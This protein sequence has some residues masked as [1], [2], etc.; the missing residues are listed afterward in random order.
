MIKQLG[1]FCCAAVLF[2][3]VSSSFAQSPIG[4]VSTIKPKKNFEL[5]IIHNGQKLESVA[6]DTP[7]YV[8]DKVQTGPSTQVII[9]FE[10]GNTVLLRQGSAMIVETYEHQKKGKIRTEGII[11]GL[12][13]NNYQ[14][15]ADSYF[16]FTSSS[17]IA[18]VRGSIIGVHVDRNTQQLTAYL[19]EGTKPAY[20]RTAQ[21]PIVTDFNPNN[22]ATAS[23]QT[24]AAVVP[25]NPDL[26]KTLQ[27]PETIV[28]GIK[29]GDTKAF[30]QPN[31]LDKQDVTKLQEST[32][33]AASTETTSAPE[34]S[35]ADTVAVDLKDSG[36]SLFPEFESGRGEGLKSK[37]GLVGLFSK[38]RE[39]IQDKPK[40]EDFKTMTPNTLK[41]SEIKSFAEK[42]KDV[43]QKETA[44]Q[45]QIQNSKVKVNLNF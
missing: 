38:M 33:P 25:F 19:Q 39:K 12:I 14:S 30:E 23:A 1:I 22:V 42:L 2:C 32:A 8:G 9:R 28:S 10:D 6:Q 11:H 27:L 20:V 7:V 21:S 3:I 41:Q 13:D 15:N 17:A 40:L 44:Q 18:G 26:H 5:T 29:T 43:L 34:E 45:R 31:E 37:S 35:S 16:E 24:G 4:K 36:S